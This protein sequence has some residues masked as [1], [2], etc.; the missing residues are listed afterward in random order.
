HTARTRRPQPKGNTRMLGSSASKSSKVKK[1][2][3]VEE[4]R[5]TLLLSKNQKTMSSEC[6]NIK[7]SIRNGTRESLATPKPRKS[8]FILRWSPTGKL[9]D[10]GGKI[11]DCSESKS[12]FDCSNG[13]NACTSNTM[14]PKINGFQTLRL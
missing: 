14:E 12:T 2:V 10:T 5:R 11:V 6:N 13:D 1:N 3:T 4:H 7:L 9:F 8:R